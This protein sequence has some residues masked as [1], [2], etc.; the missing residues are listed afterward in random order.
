[1]NKLSKYYLSVIL[2]LG[3]SLSIRSTGFSQTPE[4]PWPEGKRMALSL[5]FDD[6]RTTNPTGAA[7]L[8][9][10]D[11][12][13]TFY[14]LP[15]RVRDNLPGW[16]ATAKWGHEIAN[17]SVHHSCSGNFGWP[18]FALEDYTLERMRNELETAN[19][20][21][22]ELLGVKMVSYA[23]PCGQTTIG[24]GSNAQ[25]FVPLIS[26]MFLTGRL[27]LSEAPVDPWYCDMAALTGMKM[28][29]KNF[30]EIL[31]MIESASAKGQWLILA[32]HETGGSGSQKTDLEMLRKLCEYAKDPANG[33]WIAPVG[34]VGQ[35]VKEKREE[36]LDSINIPQITYADSDGSLE[37]WAI[38]GRGIGPK[39][40]YMPEWKAFGW[41]TGKDRIEWDA[42][43]K[44]AGKYKVEMEWSV[45]DQEAGKEFVIESGA[46]RLQGKVGK[47]GSWET[48]KTANVG[49]LELSKG[50]HRIV[51]RPAMEFEGGALLDLR[52]LVLTPH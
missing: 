8:N 49:E 25:S 7:M 40:E 2:L 11:V 46:Q 47:T 30:D 12:Q 45:S 21:I 3:I 52:R 43:L 17:H 41:F 19:A 15:S 16:E 9:E 37:L 39:I 32:G 35:Y 13:A 42:E 10:Y 14:V 22:E 27:W 5:S 38:N 26:D 29:N 4:F 31:A 18:R 24:K 28:D 44:K 6:A 23:Y 20:E 1:M 48:F 36:M 50:Y 34:T 33:I 51:F